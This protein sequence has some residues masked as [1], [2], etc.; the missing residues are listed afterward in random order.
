[1]NPVT[2]QPGVVSFFLSPS[3][4][5]PGLSREFEPTVMLFYVDNMDVN[6]GALGMSEGFPHFDFLRKLKLFLFVQKDT[7]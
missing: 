6:G 5:H 4:C 3:A 2:C 7:F 1:M